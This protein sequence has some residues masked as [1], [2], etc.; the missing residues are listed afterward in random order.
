MLPATTITAALLGLIYLVLSYRV[1]QVRLSDRVTMGD[2]GNAALTARMRAHANFAEYVPLIL[3]L[4]AL[5]EMPL[6]IDASF[7]L[8]L[9][10]A[11]TVLARVLH[12]WGMMLPAP[13][14]PRIAGT[15]LTW[16]T[17]ALLSLWAL[18]LA[19]GEL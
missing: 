19:I 16:T 13:N 10:G 11:C 9:A 3:I 17:L 8:W 1:T 18:V 5:I 15:V 2:G 14:K 7:W 4:M 6:G 12:A